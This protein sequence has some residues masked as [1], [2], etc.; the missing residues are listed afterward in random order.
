MEEYFRGKTQRFIQGSVLVSMNVLAICGNIFVC[1]VVYRKRRNLSVL[2]L[3]VL[4]LALSDLTVTVTCFPFCIQAFLEN[5]W[6]HGYKMCQFNGFVL[7]F[8]GGISAPILALTAVNRY[9][10]VIKSNIY[11]SYFTKKSSFIMILAVWV[12]T[13]IDGLLST[14]VGPVV[15]EYDPRYIFCIGTFTSKTQEKAIGISLH[16]LHVFIP[17]LI[18]VFCYTKV[19]F[20]IRRHNANVMPSLHAG[21]GPQQLAVNAWEMRVTRLLLVVVTGFLIC[22][23]PV[24]IIGVL[25]HSSYF[26]LHDFAFELYVMFAFASAVVNP[27]IYGIMNREFRQEFLGIFQC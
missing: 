21:H 8:W 2:H 6:V 22:W 24:M 27:F 17:F 9:F 4:A 26:K 20:S 18:I 14:F 19:L 12:L 7:Y 15:Y 1:W 13:L 5:R 25:A 3:F 16:L 23:I 10:R 11:R